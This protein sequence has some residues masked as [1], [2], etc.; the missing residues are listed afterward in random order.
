MAGR[1]NKERATPPEEV[2]ECVR[3]EWFV[4]KSEMYIEGREERG[5]P[6]PPNSKKASLDA[7]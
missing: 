6:T 5:H 1:A 7:A 2:V 4:S 3:W